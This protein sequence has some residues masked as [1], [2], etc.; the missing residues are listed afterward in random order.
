ML[1]SGTSYTLTNVTSNTTIWVESVEGGCPS[2][3]VPI[4][5]TVLPSPSISL[6]ASPTTICQGAQVTITASGGSAYSWSHSLGAGSSKNV[7]PLAY[8]YICSH[9]YWG[10][11]VYKY[12]QYYYYRQSKSL[13]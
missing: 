6:S 3:R 1:G 5:V 9:R 4:T 8:N 13:Q 12:C 2:A 7:T 11:W 10:K